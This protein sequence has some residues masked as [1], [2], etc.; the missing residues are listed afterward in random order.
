MQAIAVLLPW[1]HQ[2]VVLCDT[3][4]VLLVDKKPKGSAKHAYCCSLNLYFLCIN[5]AD[6]LSA[7]GLTLNKANSKN[8]FEDPDTGHRYDSAMLCYCVIFAHF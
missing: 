2:T 5:Y 3:I 6:I 4:G 8:D 7:E 1:K